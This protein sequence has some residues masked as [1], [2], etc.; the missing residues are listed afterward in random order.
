MLYVLL[1]KFQLFAI[2]FRS[3]LQKVYELRSRGK[4]LNFLKTTPTSNNK[5]KQAAISSRY[6]P[7]LTNTLKFNISSYS[8]FIQ[9]VDTLTVLLSDAM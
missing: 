8:L 1:H 6:R 2:F 5:C 9:Y 3:N 4:A 7:T